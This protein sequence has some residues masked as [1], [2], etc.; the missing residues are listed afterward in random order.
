[1]TLPAQNTLRLVDQ[2][3]ADFRMRH[4]SR[5]TEEAYLGWIRR[6]IVFHGKRHPAELSANEI[7]RFLS[8]LAT[9]RHV[10]ASTQNQALSAIL[11]LYR[12]AGG[13]VAG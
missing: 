13:T 12:N 10:S 1:M 9:E 2:I 7:T 3:R 8:A 6:F 4:Y 11:Y 5:R